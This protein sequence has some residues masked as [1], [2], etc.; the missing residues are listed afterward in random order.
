MNTTTSDRPPISGSSRPV[1]AHAP[2][3][4]QAIWFLDNLITV[5]ASGKDGAR[6]GLAV[7]ELPA[8]SCTPLHRHHDDDESFYVLEG[9]MT[10]FL[11]GGR[12]IEAQPGWFARIPHGVA[13]GFRARTALKMLVLSDP[14]GFLE[15]VREFG[16]DAP[17]RELP[18]PAAPDVP[19]LVAV[20]EKHRIE[21]IGPLPG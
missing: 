8:G 4:G 1:I 7:N 9:T 5:K 18:P 20:G 2:G 3:E 10:L 16:V 15:F 6:F 14:A 12:V 21:I 19:R 17:R 11:E 13:H